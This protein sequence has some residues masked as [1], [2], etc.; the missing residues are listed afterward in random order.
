MLLDK[1]INKVVG[2]Y[3]QCSKMAYILITSTLLVIC[4][5][6]VLARGM[7][8]FCCMITP[9]LTFT[10]ILNVLIW[11]KTFYNQMAVNLTFDNFPDPICCF[12][13]MG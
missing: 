4:A 5:S 13:K 6:S 11:H 3:R 9:N 2:D 7:D 1:N 10:N 12:M 8:Q